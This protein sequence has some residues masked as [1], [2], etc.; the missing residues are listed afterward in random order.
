MEEITEAQIASAVAEI[1]RAFKEK[2]DASKAF[3]KAFDR[4]IQANRALCEAKKIL[5]DIQ[6]PDVW[7]E[8]PR[9]KKPIVGSVGTSNLEY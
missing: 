7:V 5:R 6:F 9:E 1:H 4:D 3:K 8:S 2:L